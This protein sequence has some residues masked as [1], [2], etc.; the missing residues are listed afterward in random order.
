[1]A[2]RRGCGNFVILF[3][4]FSYLTF[5]HTHR[6]TVNWYRDKLILATF[7]FWCCC[8]YDC[9]RCVV[10]VEVVVCNDQTSTVQSSSC[11]F[12]YVK[13]SDHV[14]LDNHCS[15][16]SSSMHLWYRNLYD[17]YCHTIRSYS[18]LMFNR[19]I[20]MCTHMYVCM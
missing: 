18:S 5:P 10:F 8:R 6:H 17:F 20:Y 15:L 4:K 2:W 13:R 12:I 7:A 19:I 16:F 11:A 3:S 14:T 1:M 9:C